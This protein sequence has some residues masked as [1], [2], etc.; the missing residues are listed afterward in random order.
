LIEQTNLVA[1]VGGWEL[2]LMAGTVSWT[3]VTGLIHETEP[4][5]IPDLNTGIEFYKEGYSRDTIIQTVNEAIE[6]GK[7]WN[8][9]LQIVTAKGKDK[10]IRT[11]GITEF[12][13][14]QCIRI[15]GTFQDIDAERRMMDQLQQSEQLFRSAF[16][17]PLMGMALVDVERRNIKV[18]QAIC[19]IT[20]YSN[21]EL[22]QTTFQEITYPDDRAQ[23]LETFY[24]LIEEPSVGCQCEKRFIHKNGQLVWVMVRGAAVVG[25]DGEIVSFVMQVQDITQK[26]QAD[27]LL[28]TERKLLKTVVDHLPFNVYMKDLQSRK[29]LVNKGELAFSGYPDESALIGKSDF[30]LYPQDIAAASVYEDNEVIVSGQPILNKEVKSVKDGDTETWFLI[31]KIPYI[32][33]HDEVAGLIGISFDITE[34]KNTQMALAASRFKLRTLFDLSPVAF[35]LNDLTTGKYIDFNRA[36]VKSLGYNREELKGISYADITPPESFAIDTSMLQTLMEAGY[37]GPFEKEYFR[38]DG[39]RVPV[40]INTVKFLDEHNHAMGWSVIQDIS[41]IKEKEKQLQELNTTIEQTNLQLEA[42][43]G[44]LEQF[45]FIASHDMQEPL[46]MITSFIGL[47]EKKYADSFDSKGKEYLHFIVDGALRM[48]QII[49]DILDY[50]RTGTEEIEKAD[51]DLNQLMQEIVTMNHLAAVENNSRIEWENLPVIHADHTAMLHLFGNLIGNGLK[52]QAAGNAP[53]I[54]IGAKDMGS[55]WQFDI[56]DNGI[57]IKQENLEKVFVIFKRLHNKKEYSGTGIGLAICKKIVSG[58]NGKIWIESQ[59][60]QGSTFYFTI[61]K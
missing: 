3:S 16:E 21:E 41:L 9:E 49:T 4:G 24:K 42:K 11:R 13:D 1:V 30:D 36:L 48:R 47:L 60:G 54:K 53:I 10:W 50:S 59:P 29:T 26:R 61:P 32:N 37:C 57:G 6:T 34:Q 52:Y 40:L 58:Y 38:K 23:D 27:A 39:S 35:V 19:H 7:S 22:L 33:E 28:A 55:Q 20:G 45:A 31:S 17:S 18:N 46:R 25:A 44:E 2:D 15:F 14:N 5:Y 56:S 8:I 51:I 43:N 12:K